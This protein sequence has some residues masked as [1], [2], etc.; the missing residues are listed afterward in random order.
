MQPASF[1]S[2]LSS[3]M[4]LIDAGWGTTVFSFK[5]YLD[6]SILFGADEANTVNYFV[7]ELKIYVAGRNEKL[8]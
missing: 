2:S 3:L 5:S 6:C 8:V 1:S 7:R 4:A